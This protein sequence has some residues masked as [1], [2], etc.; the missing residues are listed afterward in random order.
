MAKNKKH[1]GGGKKTVDQGPTVNNVEELFAEAAKKAGVLY[2][3]KEQKGSKYTVGL[4]SLSGKPISFVTVDFSDAG[5]Q[6][7]CSFVTN[8]FKSAAAR[9]TGTAKKAHALYG[10]LQPGSRE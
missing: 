6:D 8:T 7:L 1:N 9:P 10:R 2:N 5:K 3:L 4:K